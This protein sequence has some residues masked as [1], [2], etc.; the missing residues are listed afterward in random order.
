[1][2]FFFF[3]ISHCLMLCNA[4]LTCCKLLHLSVVFITN[5]YIKLWYVT[6][7]VVSVV[8][9]TRSTPFADCYL[10]YLNMMHG[11]FLSLNTRRICVHSNASS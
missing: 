3:F 4:I 9:F 2:Q 8:R 11:L 5:F 6:I 10:P 7:R 1:M